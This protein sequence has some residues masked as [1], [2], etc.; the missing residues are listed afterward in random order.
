M[1]DDDDD[2][3]FEG[4]VFNDY[5]REQK[6]YV[7]NKNKSETLKNIG[8]TVATVGAFVVAAALTGGKI[9]TN[10]YDDRGWS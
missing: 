7:S 6:E 8:K 1:Y 3:G 10:P 4:R 5:R 9:N 2:D